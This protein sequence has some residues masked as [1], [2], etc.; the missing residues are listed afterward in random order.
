VRRETRTEEKAIFH[1]RR[2]IFACAAE[3]NLR[4]DIRAEWKPGRSNAGDFLNARGV[5]SRKDVHV[6]ED[7]VQLANQQLRALVRH[8]EPREPGDVVNV[9]NRDR[10]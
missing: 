5:D 8:A 1:A 6:L 9:V 2:E 3:R 4:A 7:H 10:H